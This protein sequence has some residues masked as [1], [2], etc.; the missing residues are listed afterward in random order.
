MH[1]EA[2]LDDVR[3]LDLLV[4]DDRPSF[5]LEFNAPPF[6]GYIS[7][8][9]VLQNN[10]LEEH[11]QEHS[12]AIEFEEWA[13][14]LPVKTEWSGKWTFAGRVWRSTIVSKRWMIVYCS[15]AQY[16]EPTTPDSGSGQG[17]DIP[18]QHA[19]NTSII[20]TSLSHKPSQVFSD[21]GDMVSHAREIIPCWPS[22]VDGISEPKVIDW[23]RHHI[24]VPPYIQFIKQ[25]DWASTPLGPMSKWPDTLRRLVVCMF[26]NVD[27]RIILWGENLVL[28]YN[29]AATSRFGHRYREALGKPAAEAFAEMWPY[30]SP[31]IRPPVYEG[32]ATKVFE[33][34]YF[35]ERNG[36]LEE[37]YWSFVITP[38]LGDDGYA[39]GAVDCFTEMTS[40]VLSQRRRD[41]VAHL[42]KETNDI[43]NMRE[44]WPKFLKGFESYEADIPW[45]LIYSADNGDSSST[46]S[47]SSLS[48]QIR[49]YTLGGTIGVNR[50]GFCIPQTFDLS[51]PMSD[52][53]H[54]ADACRRAFD[55][56]ETVTLRVQDASLPPDLAKAILNRGWGDP[57]NTICVMPV[58]GALAFLIVA[59]NPRV[60]FNEDTSRFAH[61]LRDIL[62]KPAWHI[63]QQR[64]EEIQD[65]LAQQLRVSSL[66]A[67]RNEAR[68][69]RMAESSPIGIS[70]FSP[71][72]ETLYVND[73]YLK[74]IGI[75]REYQDQKLWDSGRTW[76]DEIKPEDLKIIADAWGS[77]TNRT[78]DSMTIEYRLKRPWRSVDKA[79][80]HEI[81][82]ETWLLNKASTEVSDEGHLVCIHA[83]LLDVS[84]QHHI[85]NLMA[86]SLEDALKNKQKAEAFIDMVDI[87]KTIR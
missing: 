39:A 14:T 56:R 30:V 66:R 67:S 72:G 19:R 73:E 84:H 32:K 35:M 80:G 24:E 8:R 69:A 22:L 64:S 9:I 81:V 61:S 51:A 75:P 46:G 27:P 18:A 25:F 82:G 78:A 12:T 34:M 15:Q 36:I 47:S 87:A 49:S 26:S 5:V 42:T 21:C 70:T 55:T 63:S 76:K 7:N 6:P 28:L 13:R 38:V 43:T 83:W 41:I 53:S 52:G 71:D 10:A 59:L 65:S 48:T 50:D 23:T 44:L 85:Q 16:N 86:Q 77:L 31:V 79:T 33:E 62:A 3:I 68:F 57:I 74:L 1:T 11:I 60:P 40:S 37:T 17:R 4:H 58:A 29:E 54:I 45:A 2:S 20:S